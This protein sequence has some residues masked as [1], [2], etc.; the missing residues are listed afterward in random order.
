MFH[1]FIFGRSFPPGICVLFMEFYF[2]C[3]YITIMVQNV[4]PTRLVVRLNND[5]FNT[6]LLF[7]EPN[8][9]PL[10]LGEFGVV[11]VEL[12]PTIPA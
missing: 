4:T 8:S 11:V 12:R 10:L 9:L 7:E 2:Q 6:L 1:E 5:L 3:V